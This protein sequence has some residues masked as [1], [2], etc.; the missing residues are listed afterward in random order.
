MSGRRKIAIEFTGGAVPKTRK[1]F[2]DIGLKIFQALH[3]REC[4]EKE[5]ETC[6]KKAAEMFPNERDNSADNN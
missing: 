4:S 6:E 1:E 5:R 2:V 3:G